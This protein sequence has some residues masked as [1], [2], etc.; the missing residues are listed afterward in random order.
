MAELSSPIL[1]MRVRRNN[2]PASNLMGRAQEQVPQQDPQTVLALTRNQMALQSVNNSLN[3]ITGQI[4]TL[5]A[6]LQTISTQ[7][8][9]SSALEQAKQNEENRQQRVLAEQQLREGKEGLFESK[10]QKALVTPLQ[11]VG[12]AARK[13]L[14]NLGRF[15]NILL[16]GTLANRILTVVGDLSK[17]GKLNLNNLFEQVKTDLGI[18]G[19]I[20]VGINGG[21]GIALSLLGRLT[22]TLGGFAIRNLLLRPINL[23]FALAG[24]V[25]TNLANNVRNV[26][27]PPGGAPPPPPGGNNNNNNN[28]NNNRNNR[29]NRNTTGG[30]RMRGNLLRGLR[31]GLFSGAFNF[32]LGG[33]LQDTIVGSS[34]AA[35]G[36]SVG[37]PVG[38]GLGLGASFLAPSFVRSNFG[39]I[40]PFGDATMKDITGFDLTEAIM[41]STKTEKQLEQEQQRANNIVINNTGGQQQ[42]EEVQSSAGSG[43]GNNLIFVP[44]GNPNNPYM[45]HS[46]IQY[47]VG[48]GAI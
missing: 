48:G 19:G 3:G 15:F 22:T 34:A 16:I 4:A 44:P 42:P 1:G 28:T 35:L 38:F 39:T 2:I 8:T 18:I 24:Q 45:L 13:S 31:G 9:R 47:N 23:A 27:K 26:P 25:L 14:F 20:F 29:N 12:G 21:F 37:G 6:S 30:G 7:I 40:L 33:N 10:L 17:E 32:A 5:S 41:G 43:T 36:F 11:K 46:I